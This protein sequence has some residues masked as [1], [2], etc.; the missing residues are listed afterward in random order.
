MKIYLNWLAILISLCCTPGIAIAHQ[1]LKET[2]QEESTQAIPEIIV[3]ETK[4]SNTEPPSTET[5]STEAPTSDSNK[6]VVEVELTKLFPI[7]P[8]SEKKVVE[9]V[10]EAET[11]AKEEIATES[12]KNDSKEEEE[13]S[14][15]KTCFTAK[16][17]AYNQKLAEAD[18]LF[19]SGE[20]VAARKL[21]QQLKKPWETEIITTEISPANIR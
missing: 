11:S 1:S 12:S 21:Y 6:E 13:V 4:N 15:L 16:E 8:P 2:K 9:S 7:C 14:K 10:D 5:S 3:D 18:R 20:K 19:L 17:S